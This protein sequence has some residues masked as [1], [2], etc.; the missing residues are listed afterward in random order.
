[1]LRANRCRPLSK[2]TPL[3]HRCNAMQLSTRVVK[4]TSVCILGG[5]PVGLLLSSQLS[6][7]GIKHCI[8]ERRSTPTHHPQAHF[9]NARTME[10]LQAHVP[11]TFHS[12]L[13]EMPSSNNWRCF[14][15]QSNWLY[16]NHERDILLI[17][18]DS[19]HINTFIGTSSTA[20]LWLVDTLLEWIILRKQVL[21]F[22]MRHRRI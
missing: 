22:G 16:R 18:I 12:A 3:A 4:E 2:H 20:T 5:G 13:N 9:M 8:V 1:M 15:D 14:H 6:A 7:Y 11:R 10:I 19:I 17:A 21:R